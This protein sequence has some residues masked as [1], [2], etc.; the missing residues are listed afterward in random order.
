LSWTLVSSEGRLRFDRARI[1]IV[2]SARTTATDV[3]GTGTVS[4]ASQRR[5][6]CMI[7][8]SAWRRIRNVSSTLERTIASHDRV[9]LM[10]GVECAARMSYVNG[11][12]PVA[13]ATQVAQHRVVLIMKWSVRWRRR[14]ASTTLKLTCAAQDPAILILGVKCAARTSYVSGV[15]VAGASQVAQHRVILMFLSS[16]RGT[17]YVSGSVVAGASQNNRCAAAFNG[18][19]TDCASVLML[20][21]VLMT[22]VPDS[23]APK[24]WKK[25]KVIDLNELN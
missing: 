13:S 4:R 2:R 19:E 6:N 25:R 24:Y 5:A 7:K 1:I 9:I 11:T 20:M 3:S 8:T 17:S 22:N 12:L 15:A 10:K 23:V 14:N 21:I 16:A 18:D